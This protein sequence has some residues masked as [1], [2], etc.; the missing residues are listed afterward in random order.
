MRKLWIP[1]IVAAV[2]VSAAVVGPAQGQRA[3]DAPVDQARAVI[4]SAVSSFNAGNLEA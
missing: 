1:G 2:L 4:D 3:A